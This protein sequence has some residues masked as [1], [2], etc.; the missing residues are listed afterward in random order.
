M[1]PRY[2]KQEHRR[3]RAAA[4]AAVRDGRGGDGKSIV[5]FN[6]EVSHGALDFRV[7]EMLMWHPVRPTQ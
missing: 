5:D 7:A 4:P 6:A 1:A 3:G 2:S